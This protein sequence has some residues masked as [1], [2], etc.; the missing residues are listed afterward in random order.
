MRLGFT[1]VHFKDEDEN[2]TGGHSFGVGFSI[3]WQHG[4]LG[5]GDDRQAPNG[6]FVE[7]IID[8]AKERLAFFQDSK[9]SCEANRLAISCLEQAL[10]VLDQRTK[11]REARGVEGLHKS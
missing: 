10:Y 7:D 1:A 3:A 2:P 11:D 9:F 6:A 8:A 4:P 5:R